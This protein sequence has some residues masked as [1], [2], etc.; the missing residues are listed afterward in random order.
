[1]TKESTYTILAVDDARDTLM[2]LDF[3]LS[4]HGY[5]VI[6][7]DSGENAFIQLKEHDIDLVLLDIYMPNLSGIETLANI[8]TYD[9]YNHIPVIMLSASD[10]EDEIVNALDLGAADYV[11]KPYITKVLLARIR[12]AI[13][14]KEKNQ[15]LETLATTD[16]LTG[17]SNRKFFYENA[18]KS[19]KQSNRTH[20]YPVVIVMFDIDHFKNVNDTYGHDAGDIVLKHFSDLLLASFR[21]Y[22]LIARIGGEEF[23]ACMPNTNLEDALMACERFRSQVENYQFPISLEHSTVIKITTSIGVTANQGVILTLEELMKLADESLYQAKAQGRNKVIINM[24]ADSKEQNTLPTEKF[25][26]IDIAMGLKNVLDDES[27]FNEILIMF[28]ED[29]AQDDA[30]LRT[31]LANKDILT[32]KHLAHT[33]KGVASSIGATDLFEKTQVLDEAINTNGEFDILMSLFDF[34]AIELNIVVSG[35]TDELG[36][37][38]A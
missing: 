17:L 32:A 31:A 4:E 26:G 18:Q 11:T 5:K 3:D 35:I 20:D 23:A 19:I 9:T 8:R 25:P 34:V 13:R 15:E 33:L 28:Y 6:T 21:E 2:L 7:T 37:R 1:M 22:D 29:H 24:L 36:D 27:L 10:D 30:K 38:L 14:L 16:Y 12:T